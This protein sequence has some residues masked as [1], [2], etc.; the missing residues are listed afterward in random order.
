[1]AREDE[2]G[3]DIKLTSGNVASRILPV[4]IHDLD[5]EDKVLLENELGVVLRGIDFIYKSVRS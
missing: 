5:P 1:M 2:F 4:K 3:R